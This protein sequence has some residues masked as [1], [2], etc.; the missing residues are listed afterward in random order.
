MLDDVRGLTKTRLAILLV[1][2]LVVVVAVGLL[3]FGHPTVSGV[4]NQFGGVNDTTTVVQSDVYVSNP[5]PVGANLGGLSVD[6]A[7]EMNGIRMAEGTKD[8]VSVGLGRTAVP[9]RTY[10]ANER[11]PAWWVS[12]IRN[13]ERTKLT[14]DAAVHSSTV[15]ATFGAPKVTRTIQTDIISQFNSTETRPVGDPDD[16]TLYINETSAEWGTVNQSVTAIDMTF[17]V[18]NPNSYPV[19]VSRLSYHATMNGVEMGSGATEEQGTIPAKSTKT[20]HTTVRIR[21]AHIDEWWVTH[22]Q[23]DQTTHLRI[24]FSAKLD[25]AGQTVDLP[26][27]PLTYT[28]TIE[29]DI[30]DNKPDDGNATATA[31]GDSGSG[32]GSATGT[33]TTSGGLLG[34]SDTETSASTA[35]ATESSGSTSGGETATATE[36]S[37]TSGGGETATPTT[38]SG[39]GLLGGSGTETTSGGALALRRPI[40]F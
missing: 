32:S 6:Y 3:V 8:G 30:F 40:E 33:T 25:L 13:G 10:L 35:T 16:P 36:S 11:I 38:T 1:V 4:D 9:M 7:V 17:V 29:T 34:G 22:L 31:G 37:A 2:G 15:G 39:G 24:D 12:H 14:I 5:T 21:N 26:L 27:D 19:P 28:R 23:N 20:L 18:Y